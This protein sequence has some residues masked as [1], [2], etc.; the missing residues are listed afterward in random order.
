MSRIEKPDDFDLQVKDVLDRYE[1]PY[2]NKMW[3]DMENRLNR[4]DAEVT[5]QKNKK[6]NKRALLV[7]GL[8]LLSFGGIYGLY[9]AGDSNQM[10]PVMA[11]ETNGGEKE[12]IHSSVD[13]EQKEDKAIE[14]AA[15]SDV[16]QVQETNTSEEVLVMNS[17]TE[18]VDSFNE[19]DSKESGDPG[20]TKADQLK[21]QLSSNDDSLAENVTENSSSEKEIEKEEK[22]KLAVP[23]VSKKQ[24]CVNEEVTFSS[25]EKSGMFVWVV[26]GQEFYGKRTMKRSFDKPGVYNAYLVS[27]SDPSRTS[28]SVQVTVNELPNAS[29]SIPVV[30]TEDGLRVHQF[31]GASDKNTHYWNFGNSRLAEGHLAS[32]IFKKKGTYTVIHNVVNSVGCEA[33]SSLDVY[34]E[35]DFN[36]WAPN[37]FSPDGNNLNE[38]WFPVALKETNSAFTLEILDMTGK[39]VFKTSDRSNAWDG[40]IN[41]Q[42][43]KRGDVFVWRAIVEREGNQPEEFKGTIKIFGN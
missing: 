4:V 1:L 12:N 37:T 25:E 30:E 8:L 17:K 6:R 19:K 42:Y 5:K 3:E 18:K 16:Q 15:K 33:T 28:G 32:T 39:V 35:K 11:N 13:V 24:I 23:L 2:E 29:F 20:V 26:D 43:A 31:S 41:G 36:L 38:D 40:Q 9:N 27:K 10:A 21:E 7:A 22:G 14:S 34:V